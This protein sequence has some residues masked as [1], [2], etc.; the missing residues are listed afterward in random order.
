MEDASVMLA[1]ERRDR[2][3]PHREGDNGRAARAP[4]LM[5][6]PLIAAATASDAAASYFGALARAAIDDG[7]TEEKPEPS[8][9]TP[10]K[11]VLDLATVR[12]R[13]FSTRPD[14]VP[15][16]VC[17]PYAL[18]GATIADFAP[19][20]SL[21]ETLR[22]SGLHRV[23]VT[24][25][26]SAGADMRFLSIDNYL[27]DLNVVVDE[28]GTPVD[29]IGLCQ[30]GWMAL[31]FAA[32]FPGKVRRLVLAGAPV[33]VR[34]GHSM[35]ADLTEKIPLSSFEEIV[36][37]GG[38][39]VIGSRVLELWGP[40]LAAEE[41]V[42]VL[43]LAADIGDAPARELGRRFGEWYAWTLDL[44]GTYYLQVV[45]WLFKENRIADG[46][47]P[48]LGR[49]IDLADIEIPIFL[50]AARDDTLVAAPQ[51]LATARLV[52]TPPHAIETVIEPCG[53]LSLFVGRETLH[54]AWGKAARWLRRDLAAARA[55]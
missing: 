5:L 20:H 38:G 37:L 2:A 18:H 17:A 28:L 23:Y 47:F 39:R 35:I 54:R 6:W 30:G 4:N 12:L 14:G 7:R 1:P 19:G 33:D 55:S 21:V 36:R 41:S 44:P 16:L 22:E 42:Q 11:I 34:A 40:A 25:W 10:N 8:W 9:A 43:Q 3:P 26:R 49:V 51:L 27:A 48:A 46:S 15:T 50:M 31:I 24:E 45:S 29:L 52:S 53:H 32:R 13:D